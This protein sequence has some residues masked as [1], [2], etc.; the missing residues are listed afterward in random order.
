MLRRQLQDLKTDP[1]ISEYPLSGLNRIKSMNP[2][3]SW[4]DIKIAAKY[5]SDFRNSA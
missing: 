5:E 1:E 2:P 4:D 3:S